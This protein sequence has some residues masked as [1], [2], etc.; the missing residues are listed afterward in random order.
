MTARIIA[1]SMLLVMILAVPA[2][3]QQEHRAALWWHNRTPP[4]K[5]P[6]VAARLAGGRILA[7]DL[8]VLAALR[9]TV[10]ENAP[11]QSGGYAYIVE[12]LTAGI[13]PASAVDGMDAFYSEP[14]NR[15]VQAATAMLLVLIRP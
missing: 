7:T 2:R 12:R 9:G 15:S 8:P 1:L 10:P 14:D 13:R 5:L 4:G 6:L 11:L 3:S